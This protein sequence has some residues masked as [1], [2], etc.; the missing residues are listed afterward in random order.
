[1]GKIGA[2]IKREGGRP[3]VNSESH[4]HFNKNHEW[5][6]NINL[7]FQQSIGIKKWKINVYINSNRRYINVPLE[8]NSF[9]EN[10][11]NKYSQQCV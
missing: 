1:M 5:K 7:F 10:Q 11:L 3:P 6:L 4:V 9:K 8:F 2:K